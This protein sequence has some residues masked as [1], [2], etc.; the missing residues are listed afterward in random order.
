MRGLFLFSV[1]LL[2]LVG[3]D[4]KGVPPDVKLDE[5]WIEGQVEKVFVE[6]PK[7]PE[8]TWERFKKEWKDLFLLD[9]GVKFQSEVEALIGGDEK[10][11]KELAAQFKEIADRCRNEGKSDDE[12]LKEL[13]EA[14]RKY[15]EAKAAAGPFEELSKLKNAGDMNLS[16]L[17]SF[18]GKVFMDGLGQLVNQ[19]GKG[20]DEQVIGTIRTFLRNSS[21]WLEAFAKKAPEERPHTK[22]QVDKLRMSIYELSK[23]LTAKDTGAINSE[24]MSLVAIWQNLKFMLH[25]E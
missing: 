12:I 7:E 22:E 11:D 2:I 6:P 13:S 18:M 10:V 4:A 17:E 3:C 8:P 14:L 25:Q 15:K 9:E 24:F 23:A 21:A 19:L 5:G 16:E 20:N 1:F